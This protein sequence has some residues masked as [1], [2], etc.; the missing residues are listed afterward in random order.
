MGCDGRESVERRVAAPGCVGICALAEELLEDGGVGI[1]AGL[2]QRLGGHPPIV[3]SGLGEERG[4]A[5]CALMTR[6]AG[7]EFAAGAE[8]AGF[9]GGFGDAQAF[10]DFGQR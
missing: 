10:G 2:P 9:G 7:A 1:A 6:E 4:G 8:Q 5:T 3:M